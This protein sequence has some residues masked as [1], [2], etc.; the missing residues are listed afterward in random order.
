VLKEAE[1]AMRPKRLEISKA[2]FSEYINTLKV[3]AKKHAYK[4]VLLITLG[5]SHGF[6]IEGFQTLAV[7][8]YNQAN[9]YYE[10][11]E[12]EKTHE[13]LLSNAQISTL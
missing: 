1:E 12:V 13:M 8:R 6:L 10:Q 5:S 4:K 7:N 2:S 11:I 9:D 3:Y